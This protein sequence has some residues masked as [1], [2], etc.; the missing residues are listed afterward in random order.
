MFALVMVGIHQTL[1]FY[2]LVWQNEF[3]NVEPPQA[4]ISGKP[5]YAPNPKNWAHITDC[6]LELGLDRENNIDSMN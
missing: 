6:Y 2:E 5:A 4:N 1:H 3:A